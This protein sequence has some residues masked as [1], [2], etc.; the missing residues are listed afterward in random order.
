MKLIKYLILLFLSVLGSI[1]LEA[2]RRTR[3]I[4]G[5]KR[6][7][8][9]SKVLDT[10]SAAGLTSSMVTPSS[11]SCGAY[12]KRRSVRAKR[13][14]VGKTVEPDISESLEILRTQYIQAT[15]MLLL[16]TSLATK[17]HIDDEAEWETWNG[18]WRD[19]E[20]Y[21][22][23]P[24]KWLIK[25]I[26]RVLVDLD[27]LEAL[28]EDELL[29]KLFNLS[30]GMGLVAAT[31]AVPSIEEIPVCGVAV[32][33]Y[34]FGPTA[35][36][37]ISP[38]FDQKIYAVILKEPSTC[39]LHELQKKILTAYIN[40]PDFLKE[41][42]N[43]YKFHAYSPQE[44]RQIREIMPEFFEVVTNLVA[45]MFYCTAEVKSKNKVFIK[46]LNA[47]FKKYQLSPGNQSLLGCTVTECVLNKIPL[48]VAWGIESL[49]TFM[50][51]KLAKLVVEPAVR[52]RKKKRID[53]ADLDSDSDSDLKCHGVSLFSDDGKEL[54]RQLFFQLIGD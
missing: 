15:K 50:E 27:N 10:P 5:A 34:G 48:Q 1:E 26:K 41:K 24:S 51:P 46:A 32:K 38:H 52:V 28:S 18:C 13:A 16:L 43:A 17:M 37:Y 9:A 3:I 35:D 2:A 49:R 23:M 39:D 42:A 44:V 12:P 47:A 45:K 31:I 36:S 33:L 4:D 53:P 40:R 22:A 54:M 30:Y 6:P 21:N 25:S 19:W 11:D 8:A 29:V 7:R 20:D 14:N